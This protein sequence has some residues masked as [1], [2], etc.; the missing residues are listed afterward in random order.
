MAV[1]GTWHFIF[2][3]GA[4]AFQLFEHTA[5]IVQLSDAA[6]QTDFFYTFV[7]KPQHPL[8]MGDP[9]L[10]QVSDQRHTKA[11]RKIP[12]RVTTQDSSWI[13]FIEFLQKF[14][15]PFLVPDTQYFFQFRT[16]FMYSS[17]IFIFLMSSC[18]LLWIAHQILSI[19]L[20]K[21]YPL[22]IEKI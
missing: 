11:V 5:E 16:Y 9:H 8:R 13:G 4:D 7:S 19:Y 12:N 21:F 15:L 14:Y 2:F 6:F 10:L 22:T 18:P 3:T 1:S 20:W 17:L